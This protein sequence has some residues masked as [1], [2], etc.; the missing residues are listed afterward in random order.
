MTSVYDINYAAKTIKMAKA[1]T[2]GKAIFTE[3]K[4]PVKCGGA[5]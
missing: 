5:P 1:F 4:G 2:G 3:S